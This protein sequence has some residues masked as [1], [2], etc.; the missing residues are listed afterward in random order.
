LGKLEMKEIDPGQ[1]WWGVTAAE[2]W[3]KGTQNVPRI[4]VA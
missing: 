1:F 4:T 2:S 3:S